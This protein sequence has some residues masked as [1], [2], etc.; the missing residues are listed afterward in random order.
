[1]NAFRFQSP[2]KSPLFW[3]LL[4]G[5]CLANL[6]A[7][8]LGGYLFRG[9]LEYSARTE[10][11][12]PSLAQDA[13]Q[14]YEDGGAAALENWI[15]QQRESGIEATLYENGRP[16]YPIRIPQQLREALPGLLAEGRD[17]AFKPW[18][19]AYFA[20]QQVG[21]SDGK[22]RQLVAWS[23]F[24]RRFPRTE[25]AR[26]Y[27][28][29]QLLS[30][31][32]LIGAVG[33]WIARRTTRPV[34]A[35]RDAT[36]QMASGEFSTRIGAR[37][38]GA[39]DELGQLSRDFNAMAERIETLVAHERGVLQD[40]SHELRSPLARLHLILDLAQHTDDREAAARHFARAEQEIVRLDR[41]TSEI[42][43]LSRLEAGLP[44]M[45]REPVELGTLAAERMQAAR[46]EAEAKGIGL[47]CAA[48]EALVAGSAILLERALDN[49]IAN[50]L[51]FSPRGGEVALELE[52]QPGW[53][54]LSLRD[55]GP[56]VPAEELGQLFRPFF[57]GSNAAQA[58]GHGLGLAIVQRIVRVHGGEI[59]AENA[60]G[61][62]L[63]MILRLPLAAAP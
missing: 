18:P 43:A 13:E 2:F 42:L 14:T 12:W 20:V 7:A 60:E 24:E 21:A 38:S 36:R 27:L 3:R 26:I 23:R 41:M 57:R 54:E 46:I 10:L 63:R 45:E 53:A 19:G 58:Q 32:L 34:A 35:L 31:L 5:F 62:G 11:D 56:G 49:L 59:R 48:A 50:A 39:R 47:R 1:M 8:L 52:T 16:L 29:A 9:F 44:G 25:R 55:H 17:V 61:G 22:S 40:I 15:R 37:W 30:S 51:K 4:V 28:I 33:W 6:L